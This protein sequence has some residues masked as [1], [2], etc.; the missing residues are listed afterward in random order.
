VVRKSTRL[1]Q[2]TLFGDDDMDWD[3]IEEECAEHGVQLHIEVW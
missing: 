3:Q 2:M 1:T